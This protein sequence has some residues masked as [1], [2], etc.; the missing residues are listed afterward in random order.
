M[1]AKHLQIVD[2]LLIAESIR[3]IRNGKD[4]HIIY[5]QAEEIYN[6]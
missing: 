6:G 5:V 2:A 3:V 1:I 4:L